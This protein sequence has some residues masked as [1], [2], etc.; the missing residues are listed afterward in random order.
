MF[1]YYIMI[2]EKITE[3]K[4]EYYKNYR[5]KNTEKI[6]EIQRRFYLKKKNENKE[7]K[8]NVKKRC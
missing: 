8:D 7:M 6:K 2:G 5:Y 4:K 3:N 1:I